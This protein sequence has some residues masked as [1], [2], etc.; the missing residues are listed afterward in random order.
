M[1]AQSLCH[2]ILLGQNLNE[3]TVICTQCVAE[4]RDG[5]VSIVCVVIN[6]IVDFG[7]KRSGASE[8]EGEEIDSSVL[9]LYFDKI[10]NYQ[11]KTLIIAYV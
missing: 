6:L 4:D 9:V 8:N 2:F 3:L 7:A 10:R 5:L 11:P 1:L